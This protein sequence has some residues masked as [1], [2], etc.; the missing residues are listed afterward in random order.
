LLQ[1][2]FGGT[3]SGPLPKLGGFW[4]FNYQ[5]IRARNGIDPNGSSLRPTIPDFPKLPDGTTTA[6]LLASARYTGQN[7]ALTLTPA[8]IDP[9]AVNILNL[10]KDLYA[11]PFT[12]PRFDASSCSG[13]TTTPT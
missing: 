1:N 6:A 12:V 13:L 9:I 3:I 5:G 4:L 2:V 8:M 11:T 7:P 10:R